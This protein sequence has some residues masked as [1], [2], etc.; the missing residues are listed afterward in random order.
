MNTLY[1][2]LPIASDRDVANPEQ[3]FLKALNP[4]SA[5]DV[6]RYLGEI[7]EVFSY[8]AY[9]KFQTYY[10]QNKL[11]AL[12]NEA[13]RLSPNRRYP[14]AI[15]VL[16]LFNKKP[17]TPYFE[18]ETVPVCN[19]NGLRVENGI[20]NRYLSSAGHNALVDD[21][22]LVCDARGLRILDEDGRLRQVS[23]L[24]CDFLELYQ[25][26]VDNRHP[27]RTLDANYRKHARVP[28]NGY[29]GEISPLTYNKQDTEYFLMR[30]VGMEN[31]K[32]LFFKDAKN[33]KIIVFWNENINGIPMYHAYEISA[34]DEGEIDKIY[35]K[36]KRS[37][38]D[39]L[40]LHARK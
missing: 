20:I 36:G 4:K 1:L 38:V 2:I 11:N 7:H 21:N 19:I 24:R 29:R 31:G 40:N 35:R 23:I 16:Q 32:N 27:Q 15:K 13:R 39:K 25:W 34:D 12:M 33:N 17:F 5:N 6:T 37:L 14:E 9:E 10:S 18:R 28:R 3:A 26:F 30:A 22:A 8:V